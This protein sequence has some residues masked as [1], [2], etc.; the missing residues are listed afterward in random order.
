MNNMESFTQDIRFGLRSM[1]KS[2]GFSLICVFS[3][4]LGI[5]ANTTIFTVVN[6][7]LL[8]PLPVTDISRLVEI[9][10]VDSKTMVTQANATKLGMSYANCQDYQRQN[11]VL[12]G[13]SCIAFGTLT[14][15]GEAEPRQVA[16]QL[17]N[18]N[19]FE[20]LGLTPA[21][22][23]FF[24]PDEDTK[25][26]GNNVVIVSHSLWSNKLGSDPNV[27]G[28]TLTLNAT[29]YTVIGVAPRGF[30]G[31]FTIGPAEQV[32]IPVSMY[33]QALAGF[34][35]D[36]FNDRRF[37]DML[38]IGRLK[39]GVSRGQAEGELKTIASRLE[40]EYPKENGG[41]SVAVSALADAAVGINQHDQFVVAGALMMGVVGLVLLI[42]CVNLANLL[43][44]RGARR[45]REISIR[46]AVGASRLRLI[47]QL[48]TE[49][50]A[51]SL[52][53]GVVGLLLA[54]VGRR[55]LWAYRPPFI[56]RTDLDLSLDSHVLLFT[57]GLAL[58][59][60]I[61]FGLA[62]AIKASKA[63]VVTTLNAGGRSGS[64]TWTRGSLRSILVIS[65]VALAL[66]TLVGAGL[67]I[68]SMQNA[69]M[70]DVGFESKHLFVMAFDLG[71]LH[72]DEVHG[73]QFYR[74]SIQ[75][76]TALPMVQAAAVASNLPLGGGLG[77]TVFP[78]GKDETSGYRGTL[79]QL[80][81]VSPGYFDTLRIPLKKG[82]VFNDL[83]K[84]D[85]TRVAVINEAM[86]HHFWPDQD[87]IGRR[88]HFFGETQLLEVVG[89]VANTVINEIGEDPQ[90][91]AYLP[92]SQDYA[93]AATLQ[94]RTS[95][96]PR[97][98][99]A[100]VRSQIQSLDRNLAITNVQTIEEVLNQG[101]WAPRMAA[102]LLTL[103]G[104]L[105]LMLAATGVYGVL[106]YSVT[107]QT[108]EIGIRMALGARPAAVV[109]WVVGQGFRLAA[110]GLLIGLIAG[111]VLMRFV[112]SLLF[113]VSAH[114]PATFGAVALVLAIVAFLACYVPARRASRVSPLVALRY[115]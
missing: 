5:G 105:A 47:R 112:A 75:R 25:P 95:G 56:E 61:V 38:V 84:K 41:R 63:D 88:F 9:D 2:P 106:S 62:P 99:V 34:L 28:K 33:G 64:A 93:P 82:R 6:A 53:G 15:S 11:Q 13:I 52:I 83:D 81:D 65:E 54:F 43:L 89:V 39:P 44:A 45:Q 78:E 73:Q 36:N 101:L 16:G 104:V 59:T 66:I 79:T 8:N 86:A 3:L 29:P 102:V 85:T 76:A 60:G 67:F 98:A 27:I 111:L 91:L 46:T 14:W 35:K 17:V 12:S 114:D 103:F 100:T 20:V 72:Y 55:L 37:L 96:D 115:E 32:W 68:R 30:K 108:R 57:F 10:T 77:R 80:N 97:A 42:A 87:A 70:I 71:S 92:L 7:I 58:L 48:L 74:D 18:A 21:L 49:S 4:A 109:R 22:G 24:L 107:Q 90:P 40:R 50:V 31:T 26:G 110:A 19:Y 51:L 94:V 23:R 113:G 69:Q 1:R